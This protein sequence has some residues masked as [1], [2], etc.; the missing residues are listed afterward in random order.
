MRKQDQVWLFNFLLVFY[1]L[2]FNNHIYID[3][4]PSTATQN[5]PS[6]NLHMQNQ[7]IL[8][9]NERMI[10]AIAILV[11]Y[12][13]A[14]NEQAQKTL[15]KQFH[16]KKLAINFTKEYLTH[17]LVS[18]SH[19]LGHALMAKFLNG[20]PIDIHLGKNSH[21]NQSAI[22]ASK[23]ISLDGLC[24]TTGYSLY[25]IPY[26]DDGKKINKKKH[27]SILLAG[28]ISGILTSYI[29]KI[30]THFFKNIDKSNNSW[31]DLF[32]SSCKKA[33]VFDHFFV[34]QLFSML[35][36]F[37]IN[38]QV[39]ND[40]GKLYA[41]C[42]GI[43]NSY[44]KNVSNIAPFLDIASEFYLAHKESKHPGNAQLLLSKFLMAFINYQ[45][46]GF[47]RFYV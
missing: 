32:L 6:K 10:S 23:H 16:P 5:T 38:D 37:Q 36:P 35:V 2:F 29:I 13:F 41:Q 9:K 42:M 12:Y 30:V 40:A 31:G 19:E 39:C 20:D 28:G 24:P 25:T 44:L 7:N 26:E 8:V 43:P 27:A 15:E 3:S 18:F 17:F 46:R 33:F 47:L 14:A 4:A 22:L 1:L 21:K 34:E 45:L 11:T